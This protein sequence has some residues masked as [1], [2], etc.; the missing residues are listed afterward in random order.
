MATFA[1][2]PFL[3]LRLIG[4]LARRIGSLIGW[5][6]ERRD[7]VETSD[8]VYLEDLGLPSDNRVWHDPSD[9]LGLQ[10]VL[11]SLQISPD[12]VFVDYGS[13]LGR[14]LLV[15]AA[16]PFARVV[17]LEISGEL[18]RRARE[19]IDRWRR[20]VKARDVELVVTDAVEWDVA[21][22]VT[23]AYFYCPFTA[24]V[25]DA[26]VERL[27]AS[28]DEHPRPLRLVYNYPVEHS[29]L[30]RT[31]RAHVLS[32]APAQW[33]TRDRAGPN[34]IVTYLLLPK[35][36]TL[37]HEYIARFPQDVKGAEQWLGEYE[38]GYRLE[39]P[40]RLGGVALERPKRS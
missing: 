33:P 19:N 39:K 3:A 22:D 24:E 21:P 11:A 12:D 38:P 7:G 18:T 32:V 36:Q 6:V 31:G 28:V 37:R 26:A 27:L 35:D 2:V 16:F 1:G 29:R 13:G 15:A 10:R 8:Y 20:R 17:G 30:I 4:G 23:I 25:F 40:D 5:V 34:V 14:A 9:W